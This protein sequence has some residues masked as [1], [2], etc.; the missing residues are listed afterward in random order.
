MITK[1]HTLTDIL[2]L[3]EIVRTRIEPPLLEGGKPRYSVSFNDRYMAKTTR[4]NL[5]Y[6]AVQEH[7]KACEQKVMDA[8]TAA[9]EAQTA[10]DQDEEAIK[11]ANEALTAEIEAYQAE[12]KT[13]R[14]VKLF[15]QQ[16]EF[17]GE[18]FKRVDWIHT[19]DNDGYV[20][21]AMQ[22]QPDLEGLAAEMAEATKAPKK[23]KKRAKK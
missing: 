6:L 8:Q 4:D 5:E 10:E 18:C 19:T 1:T 22:Y 13:E 11:A 15:Q 12:L 17:V 9:N 7:V 2:L 14:E 23:K 20:D 3:A 16:V 21:L